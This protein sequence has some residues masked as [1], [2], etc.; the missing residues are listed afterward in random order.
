MMV[1]DLYFLVYLSA[2]SQ[3]HASGILDRISGARV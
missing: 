1:M 3:M 2:S